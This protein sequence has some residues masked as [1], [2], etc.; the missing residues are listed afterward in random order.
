M[1]LSVLVSQVFSTSEMFMGEKKE[2]NKKNSKNEGGKGKKASDLL[3]TNH[4]FVLRVLQLLGWPAC[5]PLP[6]VTCPRVCGSLV[7][8]CF[9]PFVVF[10]TINPA[11]IFAYL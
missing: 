10:L 6:A 1:A 3:Y 8:S 9:L 2:K 7:P 5:T 11:V 4:Y